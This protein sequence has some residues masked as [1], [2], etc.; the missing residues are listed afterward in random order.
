M[1]Q[2]PHVSMVLGFLLF[3]HI[4]PN[5]SA[6]TLFDIQKPGNRA[7]ATQKA[8]SCDGSTL[9]ASVVLP[10]DAT[11]DTSRSQFGSVQASSAVA[12]SRLQPAMIILAS[13]DADV[14]EAVSFAQNC[15]FQITVRSGGHNYAAL[16]SCPA[17]SS[18]CIQVD[19]RGIQTLSLDTTVTPNLAT[20]GSGLRVEEVNAYMLPRGVTVVSG[21]RNKVGV[22]GHFQTSAASYLSRAFGLGIDL[23]TSFR[24]VLADAQVH[25]VTE[26]SDPDLY[27]RCWGV[28]LVV[29]ASF[30]T[31]QLKR[32]P[33]RTT[34]TW[35]HLHM[36]T[37]TP[38]PCCMP[39]D[40]CTA[41]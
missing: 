5:A 39:P 40:L 3:V 36:S 4:H 30:S 1:V 41:L 13:S 25:V 27:W 8:A 11:Y 26:N 38:A 2:M 34:R 18:Q 32:V 9:T 37:R 6:M 28:R 17:G 29:W 19:L 10:G 35:H 21:T 16:S 24:V 14:Q 22:G 31:T 23:V 33:I 20:I 12:D 15:S 7:A